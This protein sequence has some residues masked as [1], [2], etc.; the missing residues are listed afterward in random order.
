MQKILSKHKNI[1][2]YYVFLGVLLLVRIYRLSVSAP[3]DYDSVY[4]YQ[5]LEQIAKNDYRNV[6][7]HASPAFYAVFSILYAFSSDFWFLL[8]CNAFIGTLA[9]HIFVATFRKHNIYLLLFL[10]FSFLSVASS[11]YLSIEGISLLGSAL[12]WNKIKHFLDT[13]K[14]YLQKNQNLTSQFPV[15]FFAYSL[16]FLLLF[17]MFSNY[18]AVVPMFFGA[19]SLIWIVYEK[20]DK[21]YFILNFKVVCFSII[22]F[23]IG[24]L[25]VMLLGTILGQRW[26]Q[27]PA[28]IFSI[29]ATAKNIS[30]STFD[31]SYYFRYI[32]GFEN[33]FLLIFITIA[34]VFFIKNYKQT[35]GFEKIIWF[36][37]LGTFFTMTLLAKAPRGLIFCLPLGYILAFNWVRNFYENL[38]PHKQFLFIPIIVVSIFFQIKHIFTEIYAYTPSNYPK[39]AE[40][41]KKNNAEVVF[42]TLGLSVYPYLDKNIKFVVM[43]EAKDTILFKNYSGNKFL[44]YDSYCEVSG[45]WSLLALK[46]TKFDTTFVEKSLCSDM[47]HLETSQY[48]G[49]TFRQSVEAARK[50]REEPFQIGI[51]KIK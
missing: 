18:K 26:Y 10:G 24:L 48:N 34:F 36:V 12:L 49:F 41:L 45:H 15:H 23:L 33:P 2:F 19:I 7:H 1:A 44:L 17:C 39:V 4:N 40:Y 20:N 35:E 46:N 13:S 11:R 29:I 5:I 28:T 9:V 8:Y 42:S 38:K 37:F 3:F 27:Y 14:N 50:L 30:A 25:L 43:R 21:K 47:L 51:K 6:F 31:F 22:Y 16:G 32:L